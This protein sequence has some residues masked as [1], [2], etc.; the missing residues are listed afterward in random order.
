MYVFRAFI[1]IESDYVNFH[2][3]P[4]TMWAGLEVRDRVQ[5]QAGTYPSCM[6]CE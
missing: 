1:R 4:H 3:G 5:A 6:Y 2:V